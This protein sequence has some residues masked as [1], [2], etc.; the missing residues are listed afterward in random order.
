MAAATTLDPQC[1][2]GM[3]Y[4]DIGAIISRTAEA[5]GL[6][7][8]RSYCGHGIGTLFHTAPNVPHYRR[9]KAIGVMKPGHVFTIEPMINLGVWQDVTWPDGWTSTTADGKRSAQFEH[10]VVVTETGVEILTARLPTSPPLEIDVPEEAA[11]LDKTARA[12]VCDVEGA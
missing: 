6:S 7:V 11:Y 3:M 9:N 4:R 2:P 5:R 10:T 12:K 1:R 8:V